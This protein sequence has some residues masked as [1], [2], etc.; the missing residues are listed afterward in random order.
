MICFNCPFCD[1][2]LEA[3]ESSEGRRIQCYKCDYKFLL[4]RELFCTPSRNDINEPE[5]S[6][7]IADTTP[8]KKSKTS[9][10]KVP[11][12]KNLKRRFKQ[13]KKSKQGFLVPLT[14]F[15]LSL[16]LGGYYLWDMSQAELINAELKSSK[17][18]LE[19]SSTKSNDQEQVKDHK[20]KTSQLYTR[21]SRSF[22]SVSRKLGKEELTSEA[23]EIDALV[24]QKI[25]DLGLERNAAIDDLTFMRRLY[26]DITGR[27]P[28]Y[29]EIQ[30]FRSDFSENKRAELID[31]L[32][33]SKSYVS[34]NFN[35]WADILRV[36]T[37]LGRHIH[38]SNYIE[39]IKNSF[40]ENKAYDEFV[41]EMLASEGHAYEEGNGSTG[42]YL[43]DEGMPLD[44]MA[45]TMKVFLAT[46]ITCAQCHDDPYDDWTQTDF[47]KLAAF[48]SGTEVNKSRH[49][50]S[51]EKFRKLRD[52]RKEN[53]KNASLKKAMVTGMYIFQTGV[54]KSGSGII[55]LPYDY[56]YDDHKPFDK[57]YAEVPFASELLNDKYKEKKHLLGTKDDLGRRKEF[58]KW[59]TS[60]QNP[61]FT[62]TIANRL[63]DKSMGAPLIGP[64]T[65]LQLDDNGVNPELTAK[66]IELMHKID[67]DLKEYWRVFYRTRTYQSAIINRDLK[68]KEKY[69]FQGPLQRRLS[70]EQIYDSLSSLE[71]D[72]PDQ[73][74]GENEP[75]VENYLYKKLKDLDYDDLIDFFVKIAESNAK[76]QD[77]IIKEY[78]AKNDMKFARRSHT[79]FARMR[80]SENPSPTRGD[81]FLRQFGASARTQIEGAYQEATIPQ[82][83]IL[84]NSPKVE[85]HLL[86]DIKEK[87]S[88]DLGKCQSEM[89]VLEVLFLSFLCRLP[90]QQEQEIFSPFFQESKGDVIKDLM[91]VLINSNEYKF[92]N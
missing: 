26:L 80:A 2:Y 55:E 25:Q 37:N 89:E 30:A 76:I 1:Q 40:K 50:Y 73:Y 35:Y 20:T 70:A 48:S 21:R 38:G 60:K 45:N 34:N 14:F 71:L 91:W 12:T 74:L 51:I 92:Y 90:T 88:Y 47:Y 78:E 24:L 86:K 82:A 33:E 31:A 44:N 32:L 54:F 83:L 9:R 42:Y 75:H 4:S 17:E 16:G 8:V 36:R 11:Q 49:M 84:L 87:L 18:I 85:L 27:I 5:S 46:D 63:W 28:T 59:L 10:K 13:Q 43:R 77:V 72:D 29:G 62:K 68:T 66:L 22:K 19:I 41:Y 65:D 58:A 61:M 7:I 3:P 15:A 56:K 67:Y 23:S 81:H 6:S 69:A 52:F 53:D 79:R 39:F 64:L 57:I